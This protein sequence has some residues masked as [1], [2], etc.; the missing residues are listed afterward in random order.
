MVPQHGLRPAGGGPGLHGPGGELHR[1]D[2]GEH[3]PG[4]RCP[5]AVHRGQVK[6]PLEG[7]AGEPGGY[8]WVLRRQFG[9]SHPALADVGLPPPAQH[10]P[11]GA[12]L[13]S[14]GKG[15]HQFVVSPR[16]RIWIDRPLLGKEGEQGL[17]HRVFLLV[18]GKEQ[19]HRRAS[20]TKGLWARSTSRLEVP[21][22]PGHTRRLPSRETS[23][24]RDFRI[25]G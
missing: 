13:A 12:P 10:R 23:R 19:V 24:F 3:P 5:Q 22:W 21:S 18:A 4:G 17:L 25:W 11:G 15:E 6:G 9:G 20:R 1:A 7:P 16:G 14:P 8:H 2:P